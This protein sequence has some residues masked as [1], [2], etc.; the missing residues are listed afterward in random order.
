MKFQLISRIVVWKS[1]HVYYLLIEQIHNKR[2]V[3]YQKPLFV[4]GKLEYLGGC[5]IQ[6]M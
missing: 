4:K 1:K 3:I 6:T 5:L 2:F